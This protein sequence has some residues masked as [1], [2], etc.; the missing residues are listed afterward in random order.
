MPLPSKR[1]RR[2]E[3][4]LRANE[5]IELLE[6]TDAAD[7]E[8]T[9]ARAGYEARL[10]EI[11]RSA[12]MA[13]DA[14][15][16]AG[17]DPLTLRHVAGD[18]GAGANLLEVAALPGKFSYSSLDT[19]ERCPLQYAFRYVYKIPQPDRP[20][21]AFAFGS[22][23][24][25]AFEA[26]TR[27]RRER[28]ARGEEPPTR[29]DL[30]RHFRELWVPTAYGDKPTEEAYQRRVTDLLD[31][32]W[33]GEV[34][35]IGQAIAEEQALRPGD[36]GPRRRGAGGHHRLHRPHRPAAVRRGGG[37]RLQDRQAQQPEG[38][39][40]EPPAL[41]LRPRLPGRPGPGHAGAGDPLLHRGEDS[42]EHHP[43]R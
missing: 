39:G 8:A 6:G 38:R 10:A 37:D 32:F 28:L 25:E 30:E 42:D 20:V 29:E 21:A 34:S 7:P 9:D 43:D 41:D 36:R 19:Y 1:E 17:L 18:G 4:R 23:A 24:H 27:E 14:A 3:L 22:A 16:A 33:T 12:G 2:L 5:L 15:R 35:S 31:N 11:G 13:A 26:F 40:G